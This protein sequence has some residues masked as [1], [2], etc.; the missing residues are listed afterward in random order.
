MFVPQRILVV[1]GL[2]VLGWAAATRPCRAGDPSFSD[3]VNVVAPPVGSVGF[4]SRA[5]DL[6]ALPG[7]QS[8]PPGYGEVAF[9]W[10]LGDPL[11]KERLAW[12]LEQLSGKGVMGLQINY[13]HSDRGGHSYGLTYPSDPP[14]FSDDWWQLVGWFMQQAKQRGMAISLSDYTLGIG[15]GWKVDELL[16]EHPELAGSVLQSETKEV[17]GGPVTWPL[18]PEPLMVAAFDQ[19]TGAVADLRA[20]VKDGELQWQAPPGQHRIVVVYVQKVQPSLD[21]LNPQAGPA[22]AQKFFGQFEEHNPGEGG[23]GLNFFFSDELGFRVSGNLWTARFAEEF[24]KRKGYNIVPEL[25]ALFADGGPRTPKVRLDYRDVLVSL[26]EE[27]FFKPVFDWHQGRGMIYGCDH[28]GRGRNVVE[29]GDYFRTQ[30]WNQG[31]GCDQPGLGRDLIKN[32]VA[33]SIAHLYQRPRVWLE[34]FYGSGWG[35]SSAALTDATFANFAQGQNLLTLHGLYYSTHGGWWEWAPPCNHFRMPYWQHMR[36]LMDCVQRLSYLLSQGDHRC[37]VAILYPVAPTEAGLGGEEAVQ[38]AFGTGQHLYEQGI[39]FDFMDFESLARCQVA[40]NALCVSGER[41]RVL[42]LPAMRAVRWSTLQ[43]AQEFQRAGGLVLALGALPEASDRA[44]REDPELDAAVQEMFGTSGSH[45]TS[46]AAVAERI[47]AAFPRDFA[48]ST[49]SPQFMHRQIG[50]RDVYMVYGTVRGTECTFRATGAVELWDPWTGGTRPLQVVEQSQGQT[51]LHMP[52]SAQEA[53]LIVFTPGEPCVEQQEPAATTAV[54]PVD[55]NWEF[56]LQ[57]T[58]DNRWGDFHWPATPTRIG[59]EARQFRYADETAPNSPWQEPSHDDATWRKVTCSFGPQFQKLGPL[60]AHVE[61]ER[62]D[63]VDPSKPISLGGREYPWTPYEFSWRWGIEGDPGHQGYHGLKEEVDDGF[64]GLGKIQQTM[65]GTSY[66]PEEA[67][68][69]YYLY[70]SLVAP[71]AGTYFPVFGGLAPSA[72]WINGQLQPAVNGP[73]VLQAGGNALLLRYDA[74]GRGYY[75]VSPTRAQGISEPGV[76]F[77]DAA[78]W[79]WFPNDRA[80]A[81]RFFHKQFSLDT[82]PTAARLRIT[83]DNGYRVLLNGQEVGR[84]SRWERIQQYDVRKWLRVGDNEL[85]VCAVNQGDS[86]GLIAELTADEVRVATDSSWQCAMTETGHRVPVEV[87]SG[88]PDSLWARHQFG[89]PLLEPS[90]PTTMPTLQISPLATRWYRDVSV[91]P[92][93]TRMQDPRPAGWYRFTA[94][95]GLRAMTMTA[96]GQARAW[97]DGQELVRADRNRFVVTNPSAASV[98]V[99]VRIEQERGF[100]G[101]AALPEPIALDCG[102]G[103]MALGDWSLIDG[104][105]SYSGGAWYRKTVTLNPEQITSSVILDLGNVVASAEVHING[106]LAGVRVAPPWTMDVSKFIGSSENRL[107]ILVFNTLANHYLTI[108]TRYRGSAVSGLLGP[109]RF[110]CTSHA[111][112]ALPAHAR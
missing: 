39:D 89:P 52:L 57:P 109:V 63:Q 91:L 111:V 102:P 46:A 76:P 55:G 56:E 74:P 14:L 12:Q 6:D 58:L 88:Y 82:L 110:N 86:A 106:Q 73:Q 7:F 99:A 103:V 94:P 29:F 26:T 27:G 20:N 21:P 13:A 28:G 3:P 66:E 93:D 54:I 96:R 1:A 10:W 83:C 45:V 62:P 81:E 104:L 78:A 11:T 19:A 71:Q 69:R 4:P 61:L 84:G 25:P 108:P 33:S 48:A 77:S 68:T 92:F 98:T 75:V 22:Y 64:I 105:A 42:V 90:I 49:G 50:P 17:A 15:Q 37:D 40:G 18:P 24:R 44:G 16:K 112:V 67:G 2:F 36:V 80:A 31:P 41:Y 101:G 5:P 72:V 8:P 107:E 70:T 34:G 23:Q 9:Y 60:P 87:I 79:V 59:A 85:T 38:A 47:N 65:T 100:T 53:Q 51:R 35:T 32:K 30:R 95:P 43:K 97:A